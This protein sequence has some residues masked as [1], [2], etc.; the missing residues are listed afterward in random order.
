VAFRRRWSPKSG[1]GLIVGL[2]EWGFSTSAASLVAVLFASLLQVV[3][4]A[5]PVSMAAAAATPP[6]ST[7]AAALKAAK[8]SRENVGTYVGGHAKWH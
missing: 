4:V 3:M 2:S 8:S 7:E 6:P 5:G 1:R